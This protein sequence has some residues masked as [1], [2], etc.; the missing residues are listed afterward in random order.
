MSSKET[1][2]SMSKKANGEGS[3]YLIKTGKN[4]GLYGASMT[5]ADGKR[6][7]FYGKKRQDVYEKMQTDLRE[8]EQG[9]LV[10]ASRQTVE[11]YL[12]NW[13]EHSAK[14][15]IRPRTYERYEQYVRLHII[16]PLGKI[17]LQALSPQHIQNWKAKKL[18]EGLSSTT[19]RTMHVILH[20][21][22]SDAV[23]LELVARNVTEMVSPPRKA[24]QEMQVL[25]ASQARQFM[26]IVIG[27]PDEALFILALAT[28]MRR[29]E[30]LGLK[31]Q[32]IDFQESILC[33]RRTLNRVP[34]VMGEGAGSF[35]ES[36]PK[37]MQSR[38]SIVLPGFALEA[39]QRHKQIQAEWKHNAAD[40]WEEH[41][42]AFTTPLGRYIH[43]NT[44]YAR[45]KALLKRAGLPDIRFHDLR[46]SAASLLLSNGVHPKVVQEI[47]GHS[48][49]SMT[50]DI[51]SHVLPTMHQDAMEKLHQVFLENSES[52]QRLDQN[53]SDDDPGGVFA[54]I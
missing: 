11:Q 14:D 40:A 30:L 5:L 39:L 3:I 7:Y 26:N 17:K 4:K 49:I 12:Q 46:H 22:L 32:D 25:T 41:G 47:L 28:G 19:V 53:K 35:V 44:L 54:T 45:F 9:T 21:A 16:P 37:T 6:R 20:K 18:K 31:W 50:M 27:Q 29:G 48:Q 10:D 15:H 8:K 33:V 42:Y 13:L 34:T 52:T 36:E 43:P 23:K 2:Y 51:Y 24:R 1:L 38:R